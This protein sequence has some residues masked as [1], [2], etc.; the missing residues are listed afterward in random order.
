MVAGVWVVADE[1]VVVMAAMGRG[2][3]GV[4]GGSSR[5]WVVVMT[6]VD[7]VGRCRNGCKCG[8][9]YDNYGGRSTGR[10]RCSGEG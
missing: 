10:K 4:G 1:A 8:G 2:G 9:N 3:V 6:A 5:Q 7:S